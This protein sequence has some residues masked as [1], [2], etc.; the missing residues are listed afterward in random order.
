MG[1]ATSRIFTEYGTY[2]LNGYDYKTKLIADSFPIL[3]FITIAALALWLIC[4][5]KIVNGRLAYFG[6]MAALPLGLSPYFLGNL[7]YRFDTPFMA[8][9]V[10]VTMVPFLYLRRPSLF[11]TLSIV[12][13]LVIL[14]TY[15]ASNGI[16]ILLV[17]FVIASSLGKAGG[18]NDNVIAKVGVYRFVAYAVLAYVV[19]LLIF[20]LLVHNYD[21]LQSNYMAGKIYETDIFSIVETVK[22][23]VLIYMKH[24]RGDF[25]GTV[26]MK[27]C[28][29]LTVMFVVSFVRSEGAK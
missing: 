17:L 25:R 11:A 9:S 21:N 18:F 26:F 12:A 23:N 28:L 14:T 3:Y 20:E 8:L 5:V 27:L 2:L 19:S 29:L 10:A 22:R 16:Y 13:L 6:I 7:S 15:Q 1:T 4:L 24:V